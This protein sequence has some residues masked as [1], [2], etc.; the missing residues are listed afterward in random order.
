MQS[1][2]A[3]DMQIGLYLMGQ[4]RVLQKKLAQADR[5][6]SARYRTMAGACQQLLTDNGIHLPGGGAGPAIAG[7]ANGPAWLILVI[8]QDESRCPNR[9]ADGFHFGGTSSSCPCRMS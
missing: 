4:I 8:D 7:Q 1:Q 5:G 9:H 3:V 2:P 6:H